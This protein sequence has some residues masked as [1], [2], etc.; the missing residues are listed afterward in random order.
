[1][2]PAPGTAAHRHWREQQRQQQDQQRQEQP[3]S[4][5]ATGRVPGRMRLGTLPEASSSFW[6]S[7]PAHRQLGVPQANLSRQMVDEGHD[8]HGVPRPVQRGH[9]QH[10]NAHISSKGAQPCAPAC[11]AAAAAAEHGWEIGWR[12]REDRE[13]AQR[14]LRRLEMAAFFPRVAW[15]DKELVPILARA[16]VML[17]SGPWTGVASKHLDMHCCCCCC[18]HEQA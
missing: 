18:A 10:P 12:Q 8:A 3:S 14:R 16:A 5:T 17:V 13:W 2:P 9:M 11:T 7:L 1:M 4:A 6:H 15:D